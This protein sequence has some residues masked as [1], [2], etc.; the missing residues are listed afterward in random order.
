MIAIDIRFSNL[1][2]FEL[3]TVDGVDRRM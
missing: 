2:I 3:G 1:D